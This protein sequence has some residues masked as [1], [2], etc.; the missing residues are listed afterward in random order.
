MSSMVSVN[1]VTGI[2]F[3]WSQS[4]PLTRWTAVKDNSSS[5]AK[6]GISIW[7]I[8]MGEKKNIKEVQGKVSLKVIN[9]ISYTV[10][11]VLHV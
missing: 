6:F 4:A 9:L 11:S 7:F 5:V 2:G 10:N 1:N 8:L 3:M